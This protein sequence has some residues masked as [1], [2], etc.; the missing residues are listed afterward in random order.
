MNP[1]ER[2]RPI[3]LPD[4]FVF[5]LTQACNHDCLHCYNCW[6]NPRPYPAGQ[7]DTAETV[8]LLDKILDETQASLVTLKFGEPWLRLPPAEYFETKYRCA[9]AMLDIVEKAHPGLRG[10]IEEMEVA[11]PLTFMRYLGHPEGSIYGFEQHTKDSLFFRPGYGSPLN[12]LVFASGWIGDCGFQPTLEA[13]K[14]AANAILKA[15]A[16]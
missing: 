16:Q 8:S 3:P 5:E 4:T 13:G 7:L 1:H 15:R 11:T 9:G 14:S 12:G 6:K 10:H 2:A